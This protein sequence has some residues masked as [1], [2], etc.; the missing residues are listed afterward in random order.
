MATYLMLSHSTAEGT[1]T[2]KE[3]WQPERIK[4]LNREVETLGAK[5]MT[6]YALLGRYDF[7][8]IL[9]APNPETMAR[10]SVELGRRGIAHY[11]TFPA[12]PVETFIASLQSPRPAQVATPR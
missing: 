9:E 7:A 3:T 4:D 1:K 8:T 12:I 2:I 11:E 10:V 5:V 6:Q